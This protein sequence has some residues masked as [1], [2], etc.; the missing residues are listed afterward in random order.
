[1]VINDEA[2]FQ[3][4]INIRNA[5]G[6]EMTGRPISGLQDGNNPTDAVNKSQLDATRPYKVYSAGVGSRTLVEVL[7]PDSK[8]R[9]FS[10]G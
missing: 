2:V 4:D 3:G 5:D 9:D 1:M 6:I 8:I 10:V 7:D